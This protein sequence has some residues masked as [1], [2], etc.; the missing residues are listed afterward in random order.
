DPG[1]GGPARTGVPRP[2]RHRGQGRL[3]HRRGGG[4]RR[5]ARRVP[6]DVDPVLP[7]VGVRRRVPR[8]GDEGRVRPAAGQQPGGPERRYR[9]VVR[10]RSPPRRPRGRRDQRAGPGRRRDDLQLP[11]LHRSRRRDP[12]RPPQGHA[13]ERGADDLGPGGREHPPRLRH[14]HRA[15]RRADLLGALDA[16]RPVRDA[17]APGGHPRGGVARE[18]GDPPDGGADLRLRGALLRRLRRSLPHPLDDPGGLRGLRRDR[19][20]GRRLLGRPRRPPPRGIGDRRPRWPLAG[21]SRRGRGDD[22]LRRS[23]PLAAAGRVPGARQRGPLQPPRHLPA[24]RRH[25][26]A[27]RCRVG[28]GRVRSAG[29]PGGLLARLV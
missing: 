9:R 26:P 5:A 27:G 13:D 14:R 24:H 2:R 29:A 21:G 1:R 7:A 11:A 12:R 28:S 16:P 10:C 20:A 15:P 25:A 18:P 4:R 8:A 23:R 17:R 19:R 3:P 22:R 6:R